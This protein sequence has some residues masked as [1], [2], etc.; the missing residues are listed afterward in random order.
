M[1]DAEIKAFV[2]KWHAG[3]SDAMANKDKE[4][5]AEAYGKH[6]DELSLDGDVIF[7]RPSGN[8]ADKAVFQVRIRVIF[9]RPSGNPA[10]KAVF[11]VRIRRGK[12][13][14][15]LSGNPAGK[16]VFQVRI[17]RGRRCFR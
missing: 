13:F 14:F 5:G 11:Q 8:P 1:A 17:R 12:R 15:R 4:A 16:A 9:I 2:E 6:W 10:D 3:M 7:I